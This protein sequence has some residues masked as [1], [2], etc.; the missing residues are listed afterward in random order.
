MFSEYL[1]MHHTLH[2]QKWDCTERIYDLA[3]LLFLELALYQMFSYA[4]KYSMT[5]ISMI[6]LQAQMSHSF[7]QQRV[8]TMYLANMYH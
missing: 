1:H 2:L 8:P 3:L 6:I 4:T 7:I 5:Q